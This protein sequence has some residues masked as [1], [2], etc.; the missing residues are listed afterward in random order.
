VRVCLVCAR[1]CI[2]ESKEQLIMT[3]CGRGIASRSTGPV[4]TAA[5]GWGKREREGEL[6]DRER[7]RGEERGASK[8]RQDE[9]GRRP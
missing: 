1:A 4:A 8:G 7:G 3:I 2:T 6:G 9:P 5:A